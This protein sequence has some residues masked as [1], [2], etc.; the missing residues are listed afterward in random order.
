MLKEVVGSLFDSKETFI[1][2]QCNCVT[3]KS[4]HLSKDMFTTYPYADVYTAREEPT[5]PGTVELRG[6]GSDE[7]FVV[8]MFG[9]YYP[10]R[11][12]YRTGKDTLTVRQGYFR[13]CLEAMKDLKGSFAFPCR[14]GCGA[15]GGDW[16]VYRK[17]IE[18]F[19]EGRDVTIYRLPGLGE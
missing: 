7:R 3:N 9:Q 18:E 10:G 5:E 1:C 19:A 13:R 17:M 15:A 6:N 12:K 2:H 8:N 11:S 16:E 14:I 4:A